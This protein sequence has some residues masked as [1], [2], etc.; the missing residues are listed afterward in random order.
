MIR[1]ILATEETGSVLFIRLMVGGIFLSE[2]LQKFIYPSIL[3]GGRFL[4]IGFPLPYFSAYF[5][6]VLQVIC[7]VLVLLGL[8]TRFAVIPLLVIT[9]FSL[10][11]IQSRVLVD[12]GLFP[13]L[14]AARTDW[15]MLLGTC[16]LLL[17]GGGRWS[18]D[19]NWFS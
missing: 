12:Q 3:G 16:Y 9:I 15:C 4:S 18:L 6:G 11:A 13:M 2:G 1:R 7:A 17:K 8:F 5:D 14:H 10:V 19:R